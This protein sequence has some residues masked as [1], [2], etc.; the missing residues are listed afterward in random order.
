MPKI[1]LATKCRQCDKEEEGWYTSEQRQELSD[2]KGVCKAC[3]GELF[4]MLGSPQFKLKRGVGGFY[5]PGK[6]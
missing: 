4:I 5:D 2:G 3:G 1:I 6:H